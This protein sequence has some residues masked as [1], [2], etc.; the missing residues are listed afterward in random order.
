M[1]TMQ[2][3]RTG[4][5]DWVELTTPDVDGAAA[6]YR[7]LFEWGFDRPGDR[8]LATIDGRKAAGIEPQPTTIGDMP[9]PSSWTIYIRV[10][11]LDRT[12]KTLADLGGTVIDPPQD[13]P[14]GWRSATV[15]D[16]TGAAFALVQA[17]PDF[18]IDIKEGHGALCWSDLLTRDPS[19]AIDFYQRLLGWEAEVDADSGYTMFMSRGE[20]I[21][22][23]MPMPREV[24]TQAPS[25]WLP[26]FQVESVDSSCEA[27]RRLKGS[28]AVPPKQVKAMRFAVIEDPAEATFGLLQLTAS[29]DEGY[30]R[31]LTSLVKEA[32][33]RHILI[34]D[35]SGR[36]VVEMPI[37]IGVVGAAV[38]PFAT[39]VGTM[40]ALAARWSISIVEPE[41][42]T[43][44]G[45][46]K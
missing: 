15:A 26:Y 27:A 39:A 36:R 11:D 10:E 43:G 25:H 38:A 24:P 18:G 40:A 44:N 42:R 20:N 21:A 2:A 9:L 33:A 17:S 35:R 34:A 19:A 4:T 16:P 8:W 31:R 29:P 1:T 32:N 37:S 7:E 22:G 6:F 46:T 45:E 23:M 3:I 28:V 30:R 41:E 13:V 14:E 12:L 5:I